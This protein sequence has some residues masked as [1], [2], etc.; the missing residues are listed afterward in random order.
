MIG[1]ACIRSRALP[2]G[3]FSVAGIST[4]HDVAEFRRRTPVAQCRADI[5]RAD[6]RDFCS[7]HRVTP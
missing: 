2:L 5:A 1:P 6:D 4:Q 7:P 3:M